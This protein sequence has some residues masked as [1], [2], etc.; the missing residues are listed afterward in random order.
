MVK[1]AL[2]EGAD[3]EYYA[4]G[5]GSPFDAAII[6]SSMEVINLLVINGAR[7]SPNSLNVAKFVGRTELIKLIQEMK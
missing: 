5:K 7:P 3:A 4:V 2:K 6:G 1:L